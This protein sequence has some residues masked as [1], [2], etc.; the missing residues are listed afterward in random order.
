MGTAIKIC[1]AADKNYLQHL[2][3]TMTSILIH[4]DADDRFEFLILSDG[5]L[6][7]EHFS[8]VRK[9]GDCKIWIV[10]ADQ[11][12][13]ECMVI[14]PNSQWSVAVYYRLL[15][16]YLCESDTRII[17]LDCDI[18][19]RG[20]LSRLWNMAMDKSFAGVADTGFEHRDRLAER[21]VE[22]HGDYFNSG[23]VV[24][25]LERIR[26]RGYEKLLRGAETKLPDPEFPDQ[27]WLNLMFNSDKQ[28]IPPKW[29]AMSHLFSAE[30]ESP[31]PYTDEEVDAA[32]TNP[33][34][35]HFTNIKPWTMTYNEHPFWFEYWEVLKRTQFAWRYPFGYLKRIFLSR[36]DTAL[37][38]H[39][40]P[41]V[42]RMLGRNC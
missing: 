38:R 30:N 42:K 12:V 9:L 16:P 31:D 33:K 40:R 22:I 6:A 37:F 11:L 34:I 14:A 8:K 27:D 1:L 23:V 4:A 7:E 21:S 19:V 29:N 28:L 13:R 18:I 5:S 39:V 36:N 10:R 24:L 35:C 3:V 15:L 32:R 20:S 26:A 41:A 2:V 25:N 17:Y